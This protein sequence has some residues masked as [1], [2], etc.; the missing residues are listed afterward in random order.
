[1]VSEN[2]SVEFEV[3]YDGAPRSDLDA[4]IE[5]IC[6]IR[7]GSGFDLE[8]RRRELAFR[9]SAGGFAAVQD[10]LDGVPGIAVKAMGGSI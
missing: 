3:S 4:M 9:M 2:R 8:R 10:T 6:G 5:G 7:L 1:M